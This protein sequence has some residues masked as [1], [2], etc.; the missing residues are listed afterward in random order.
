MSLSPP[1]FVS[2]TTGFSERTRSIPGCAIIH[3]V[4]ASAA[5]QTHSVQVS[6]T[7]VSSSPSSMTC[8]APTSL[9]NALPTNTAAGTRERYAFPSCGRI[10]VIPVCTRAPSSTVT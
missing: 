5:F 6:S 10:A 1:S 2:P 8:V 7:G 4:I 3:S 9:P